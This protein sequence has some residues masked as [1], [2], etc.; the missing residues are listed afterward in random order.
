M[1]KNTQYESDR[2]F[3]YLSR[4]HKYILIRPT[5]QELWSLQVGVLLEIGSRQM[6]LSVQTWTLRP[7]LKGVCKN[8]EYKIPREFYNFLMVG[9]TQNFELE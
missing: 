4:K 1:R 6:K 9:K 2:E 5:V 8:S 3:L 7:L